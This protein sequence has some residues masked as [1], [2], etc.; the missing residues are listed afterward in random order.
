MIHRSPTGPLMIPDDM[1]HALAQPMVMVATYNEPYE[2]VRPTLVSI[3]EYGQ[4]R[5]WPYGSSQLISRRRSYMNNGVHAVMHSNDPNRN[6][7][8]GV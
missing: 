7:T 4:T 3:I 2:Y 1:P 8:M 5:V 6:S